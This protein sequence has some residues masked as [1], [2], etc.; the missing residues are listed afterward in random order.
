MNAH[1]ASNRL[2]INYIEFIFKPRQFVSS[3]CEAMGQQTRHD[4][5]A[6]DFDGGCLGHGTISWEEISHGVEDN[7]H[8]IM[9]FYAPPLAASRKTLYDGY[10]R[11]A[12]LEIGHNRH[13]LM[14]EGCLGVDDLKTILK[15]VS[16]LRDDLQ[17][18]AYEVFS[19]Y[20]G[21]GRR[22]P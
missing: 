18:V 5:V 22:I 3:T 17:S 10:R 15:G 16:R 19:Q 20:G 1:A 9:Q 12:N 7:I 21:R 2:P 8:F 6:R 11:T 13:Q 4:T 14:D